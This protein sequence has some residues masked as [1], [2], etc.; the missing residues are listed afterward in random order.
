ML[1][2]ASPALA[3]VSGGELGIEYNAPLNGSDFGGTTYS[4][5]LGYGVMNV[6]NVSANVA[7]YKFD[8]LGTD[9]SN[10]TLH[11]TYLMSSDIGVGA[12]VASDSIE[13]ENATLVGV[14]GR[15]TLYGASLG[16]YLGRADDGTDTGTIFGVDGAYALRSG[17]SAIGNIDYFDAGGDNLSQISVGGE[18]QMAVG[19]QFYAQIG[20]VTG[21][22]DGVS[23]SYG[24]FT[25][26]A[27]VAFGADQGTLFT[28]RSIL[29]VLPGF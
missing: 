2:A 21:D 16:G 28:N 19:P 15:G 27:K 5:G 29:E 18:Y 11:A 17:F 25:V 8:N 20:S 14:E 12:F 9:A 7:G 10:V 22:F 3:Q 23:E 24:F 26:G 4:G 1:A 6:A 13:G